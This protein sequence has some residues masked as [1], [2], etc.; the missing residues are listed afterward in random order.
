[1]WFGW[2]YQPEFFFADCL[3][4]ECCIVSS[5]VALFCF[6]SCFVSLKYKTVN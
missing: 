6:F 1:L 5:L 3:M 4:E 2:W